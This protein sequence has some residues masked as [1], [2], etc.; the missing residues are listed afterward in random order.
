MAE[1][2]VA[3]ELV[4]VVVVIVERITAAEP[5]PIRAFMPSNVTRAFSV[6]QVKLAELKRARIRL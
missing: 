5:E 6:S 3:G 4:G 1:E 2:L